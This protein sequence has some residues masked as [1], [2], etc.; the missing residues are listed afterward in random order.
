[1]GIGY[2]VVVVNLHQKVAPIRYDKVCVFFWTTLHLGSKV[3]R[4]YGISADDNGKLSG[5]LTLP[6]FLPTLALCTTSFLS[7][8]C[9]PFSPAQ[10]CS[11]QPRLTM[12]LV[13]TYQHPIQI[14][15]KTMCTAGST[16]GSWHPLHD[17]GHKAT[18]AMQQDPDDLLHSSYK[19]TNAE[20]RAVSGCPPLSNMVTERWLRY[21]GHIT[22]SAPDEDHHRAVAA[23]IRKPPSDWKWPPGRPNHM[24]V[25]AAEPDMRPLN[26]GPFYAWKKAA[27]RENCSS[28]RMSWRDREWSLACIWWCNNVTLQ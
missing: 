5:Q 23:M 15:N 28:R 11:T 21:Y 22:R 13:F 2:I 1:M 19:L 12:T 3:W 16:P 7:P 14:Y 17:G 24:W 26:I 4:D 25:R 20:A 18:T 6:G 10:A 8:S 9:I 27:S